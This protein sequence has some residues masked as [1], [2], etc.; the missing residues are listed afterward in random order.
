MSSG[1]SIINALGTLI[2]Y[3]GAEV[4]IPE[5]F[6]RLLWPERFYNGFNLSKVPQ[7]ALFMPMGGP[8]HKAA[9]S[10]LDKLLNNGLFKGDEQG[11]MLGSPFY[12]DSKLRYAVYDSV[13]AG[14]PEKEY[15]RNGIWV[16]AIENLRIQL[17]TTREK[18]KLAED[19]L[20]KDGKLPPRRTINRVSQLKLSLPDREPLPTEVIGN[21]IRTTTFKT[22]LAL[23][24]TE[25]TGI[26]VG[27]LVFVLWRSWFM[28]L[29]F[30]PLFLK[31]LSA[32]FAVEREGLELPIKL[33]HCPKPPIASVQSPPEANNGNSLTAAVEV[34]NSY[35]L[36][37]KKFEILESKGGFLLIEGDE[38]LILQF[39]RHYGHPVRNRFREAVQFG[40]IIAFGFIFPIGLL[41]SI[42]WMSLELQYMWLS[43]QLYTT[44]AMHVYRY[45]GGETWGTT[46]E[47]IAERFESH[48]KSGQ[49]QKVYF[50]GKG[51]ILMAELEVTYHDR[52]KHGR[53]Y[54]DNIL[55]KGQEGLEETS[56]R[57]KGEESTTT[58]NSQNPSPP[59]VKRPQTAGIIFDI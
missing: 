22:Y 33:S 1:A 23:V 37:L 52:Y 29:W 25:F 6:E 50:A 31:L 14:K 24:I 16:R 45:T 20:L 4:A 5:I 3:L 12:R 49:N 8:L 56:H 46:E 2:G 26:I 13:N 48:A 41:C 17:A 19:G 55:K 7:M 21:E 28:W 53:A 54:T 34:S 36:P 40:C 10:T 18:Q 9:L 51:G 59:I 42:V 44:F 32:A 15:V 57:A 39:F 30:A 38:N 11:H 27:V 47:Q 35:T 43:Y 58:L